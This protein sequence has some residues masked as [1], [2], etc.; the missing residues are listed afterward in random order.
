MKRY[1]GLND[2]LIFVLVMVAGLLLSGTVGYMLIEGWGWHDA[3]FMTVITLSTV[4]YGEVRPLTAVGES[5]TIF[6]ILLGV[7]G[8]AYTFSTLADYIVAGELNGFLR[9]QRMT[10]EISKLR[11][12]YIICGYGRV[13]Q[14]VA[15]GLRA[16]NYDV[17][18]IDAAEERIGEFEEEGLHYVIGD[19]A[20]DPVLQQAGIEHASGLCTCLP[21]DATNV[22]VVLSARTFN[23][24]LF[25]ISRGNLPE[26]E[27]K[28]RIAGANQV[29][30]PYTITGHRMAAQLLH[31]SVV[32]FLD[33]IVRA[34]EL[35]LRI[36][37]IKIN[38]SSS[39]SGKSLIECN[40]RGDTGVNVLAIRRHDGRL[41]THFPADFTLNVS[42]ILIGLGTQQQLSQ[43]AQRAGDQ[44]HVL[45]SPAA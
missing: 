17:V 24:D 27:R 31:P 28:L 30:N 35:E 13:G 45:R 25:I 42:D 29:I 41:Y 36:E 19:A 5:F 11:N 39:M 18:V 34:G 9:R 14:Q 26:S 6:L 32:E 20:S 23:P 2:R 8:V 38:E 7:G 12:H 33:V 44:R 43:L 21:N 40:V 10:R 22:F 4:G 37:E 3:F 16:N 1:L 15:R